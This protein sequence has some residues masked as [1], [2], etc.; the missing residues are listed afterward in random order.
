[1]ELKSFGSAYRALVLGASGGIGRALAVTP[2]SDDR[3]ENIVS[4]SRSADGFDLLDETSI[5]E[6]R[7]LQGETFNLIVYATGA[8]TI[9]GVGP[10]KSILQISP[11]TMAKQ[12]AIKR[13]RASARPKAL[14]RL[15]SQVRKVGLRV[16]FC[17]GRLDRR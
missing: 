12:F 10:D 6:A 8:L 1:M 14:C 11:E 9:D 2:S 15:A 13:D 4:L 5:T 3:C 16:S 17:Q 7:R